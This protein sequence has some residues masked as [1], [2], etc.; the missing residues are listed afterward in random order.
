MSNLL[1]LGIIFIVMW[2][3]VPSLLCFSLAKKGRLSASR[4]AVLALFMGL[5]V[6]YYCF[7]LS[8]GKDS[9]GLPFRFVFLITT[10]N[11]LW[12]TSIVLELMK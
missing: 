10:L 2:F 4:W 5:P 3:F 9:D 11:I 8:L 7:K 12:V 1:L 6:L